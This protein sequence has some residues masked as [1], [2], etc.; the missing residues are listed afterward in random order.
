MGKDTLSKNTTSRLYSPWQLD[1]NETW[2]KKPHRFGLMMAK[3]D[4]FEACIDEDMTRA[5]LRIEQEQMERIQHLREEDSADDDGLISKQA[6]RLDIHSSSASSPVFQISLL[7]QNSSE[8]FAVPLEQQ[9]PLLTLKEAT[10]SKEASKKD[11]SFSAT[12]AQVIHI[13]KKI[14][15]SLARFQSTMNR[16]PKALKI[17]PSLPNWDEILLLT[18]PSSWTSQATCE[19]TRLFLANVKATQTKHYFQFV[20]LHAVR[21]NLAQSAN[22]Q[23][24]PAL[25]NALKKALACN[26]ALFMKGLLFP[27]CESNTC[28]VAEACILANVLGQVKIPALQSATALLRL[29][30]QLFTLPICILVQVFVQKRQALPYRVVDTLTFKYF[31]QREGSLQQLPIM[32]YQSLLIF[33]QSYSI[34]MVPTQKQALLALIQRMTRNDEL[35]ILI[36]KTIKAAIKS[37]DQELEAD[38]SD[39]T[40][41]C[42]E[43][44]DSE[45]DA[46]GMLID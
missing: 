27:L 38:D 33:T 3:E 35:S 32:W 7:D 41:A 13:Y 36:E 37:S 23:L 2:I 43:D 22:G 44:T 12:N 21:N 39:D 11:Q 17:I 25:Y 19:V 29:S 28:T 26:P 34:D 9:T 16:L 6:Q 1:E 8:S 40:V 15:C 46:D 5:I 42:N 45:H 18:E 30:E 20:L 31:C 10:L 24:D 14:G 4:D